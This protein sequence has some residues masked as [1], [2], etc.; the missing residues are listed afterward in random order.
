MATAA[1]TVKETLDQ[2]SRLRIGG[3]LF[4]HGVID[5]FSYVIV[6][7]V[8]LLEGRVH[9]THEQGALLLG[10]GSIA[11]GAIQ[12]LAA[13]ISDRY[14]TRAPGWIGFV[15]AVIAI[16]L[17]GHATQYWHLLV[18][19]IIGSAGVGAYHPVAAAAVGQLAG[20]R[21]LAGM[22]AFFAAGMTGGILGNWTTPAFVNRLGIESLHWLIPVGLLAAWVLVQSVRGVEHGHIAARAAHAELSTAEQRARWRGIW[23][24]YASNVLRFIVNMMLVQ[25]AIRWSEQAVLARAEA[26]DLDDALRTKAIAI[27]GPLQASMQVGMGFV[28]LAIALLAAKSVQRQ[29]L[30]WT[31]IVCAIPL[32]L[33]PASDASTWAAFL[34]LT[35]A[36][37]GFGGTYSISVS[38]GQQLLPHRTNLASG[39]LMG[40]AWGV[41]FL[42][43]P[44][45]QWILDQS[46]L[47]TA[48][49]ASGVLLLVSGA[50][51]AFLPRQAGSSSPVTKP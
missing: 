7:I 5:F 40:G 13:W 18:I 27:N 21:R 14:H 49:I 50:L 45:A 38:M 30:L 11:S 4:T 24:L 8:T 28:G 12:P 22:A 37:A 48:F 16:S 36:G 3:I 17:V 43:P 31:P 1:H 26:T 15:I 35:I 33:F 34:A 6:P 39:L 42:G 51:I 25:L 10:L 47:R 46:N 29:W 44:L 41:A 23:L 19:Q 2:R 9:L 32:F 20:A